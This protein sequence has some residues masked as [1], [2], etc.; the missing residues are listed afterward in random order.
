M[1]AVDNFKAFHRLFKVYFKNLSPAEK[2]DVSEQPA[3]SI[4]MPLPWQSHKAMLI[5]FTSMTT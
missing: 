4:Y 2:A 3:A 5:I 1:H